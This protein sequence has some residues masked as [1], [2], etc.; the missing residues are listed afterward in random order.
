[1]MVIDLFPE[2]DVKAR[3]LA[4]SNCIQLVP[5]IQY[6]LSVCEV[7][8]Y[9][10]VVME[11]QQCSVLQFKVCCCSSNSC[12]ASGYLSAADWHDNYQALDLPEFCIA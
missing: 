7:Y 9:L 1:M 12:Y 3:P 8:W 11:K 4:A 6:L 10:S 5:T 2:S